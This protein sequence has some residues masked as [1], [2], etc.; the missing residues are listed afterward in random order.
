MSSHKF[1][2]GSKT[3]AGARKAEDG[4][5]VGRPRREAVDDRRLLAERVQKIGSDGD[6]GL[7]RFLF[8]SVL[9]G[10]ALPGLELVALI[11][12]VDL[13]RIWRQPPD[14]DLGGANGRS[15]NARRSCA[16]NSLSG[17]HLDGRRVGSDSFQVVSRNLGQIL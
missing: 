17:L 13:L 4:H 9:I 8:F 11:D 15:S 16:R 6:G 3:I 12:A 10:I 14:P 7:G 1:G 5:V 2:W